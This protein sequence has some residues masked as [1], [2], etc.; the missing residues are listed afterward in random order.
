[1]KTLDH[2][3]HALPATA[4]RWAAIAARDRNADGRFVFAVRTTGI[5]CRPSCPSRRAR[6]ENVLFFADC[7]AAERAGFRPCRRCAPRADTADPALAAAVADACRR[8]DAAAVDGRRVP[9]V[10][11]AR[12][13]GYSAAHLHRAFRRS[14]GLTPREY[15]EA[16]RFERL[17]GALAGGQPV[18][19]AI[20]DAGF[21]A[22]SRAY[23]G[24]K[25]ALGTTPAA[26]RARAGGGD[27][28]YALGRTALG[29]ALLAAT[30]DGVSALALGDSAR[31]LEAEFKAKHPQ[32][33]KDAGGPLLK[34][35]LRAVAAFVVRPAHGLELP[36]DVAGTA[37]QR[38]VWKALTELPPGTTTSYAGLA[39]HI[40]APRAARA[41]A[42]ACAANPVALAIPCHRVVASDGGLAGYRWG[43]ARKAALLERER[44]AGTAVKPAAGTP[45]ARAKAGGADRTKARARAFG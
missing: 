28:R 35:G 34:A 29:F 8:L 24:A 45:P 11:L 44:L 38:R 40:G 26:F 39:A 7:A 3:S 27:V 23:A 21:G 14:T 36:L 22:P 30:A 19:A 31:A 1:M 10:E 37:F 5:F 33:R 4:A 25:R 9:L 13:S 12:R 2:P 16:A 6:R 32:A 20:A 41:V 17:R 15:A 43:V 42:S 18:L